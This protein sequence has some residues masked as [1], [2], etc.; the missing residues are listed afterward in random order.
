MSWPSTERRLDEAHEDVVARKDEFHEGVV[1]MKRSLVLAVGLTLLGVVAAGGPAGAISP[2]G[3]NGKIAFNRY[4]LA[5]DSSSCFTINPDGT[6][7][8]QIGLGNVFC[9][10]W[11]PDSSKFLVGVFPNGF[12]RPATVNPD[13]SGLTVLDAYPN[14]QQ[15]FGCLFW[16][17]DS[18]RFL[19]NSGGNPDPADNGLYTLSSSD[20]TVVSRVTVTPDGHDD[21]PSGYS[22]NGSRILFNRVSDNDIHRL[23]TVNPDGTG[24]LQLSPEG[25][26]VIDLDFFDAVSADW[27]PDG[28]RVTF[29]AQKMSTGRSVTALFIVNADGTGLRQ[30]APP[31]LGA[32]SAQWSPNGHLI[33]FTSC[34][35]A[36]QA[37]VVH[38]N[39][40]GLREITY[41][42]N[43]AVSLAPIWSPDSQK[44]LFQ[45]QQRSGR[46]LW[47]V[48]A[49]GTGLS[50]LTD[51][52][53][54]SASN[55]AWGTAPAS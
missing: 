42:T 18:N 32:I 52:P 21:Y 39:G 23:F 31:G 13:G 26:S 16:S 12:A 27:S 40:T 5:A 41:S 45:R 9:N 43:G 15:G 2:P 48:N 28:A 47:T 11:S 49:D 53:S 22:P 19:C 14:L 37:W 38:P 3:T 20:G 44:L 25:M 36:P 35:G 1:V 54:D 55:Y 10:A 33:A 51:I 24:L 29:A 34:C 50:K 8:Q 4:D 17:P 7:E 30:I 6:G 46:N